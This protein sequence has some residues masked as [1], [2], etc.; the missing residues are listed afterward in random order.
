MTNQPMLGKEVLNTLCEVRRKSREQKL[1]QDQES[2]MLLIVRVK[3][4]LELISL[5]RDRRDKKLFRERSRISQDQVFTPLSRNKKES[6]IQWEVRERRRLIIKSQDQ[7]TMSQQI[8]RA[9]SA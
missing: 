8:V 5:L 7:A 1:S 2:I 9:K 4:N 3:R 6:S